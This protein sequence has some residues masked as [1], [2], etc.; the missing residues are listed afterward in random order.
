M[1]VY[2]FRCPTCGVFERWREYQHAGDPMT[3]DACGGPARRVYSVPGVRTAGG[4]FAGATAQQRA[5]Y[6]RS[7]TGEPIVTGPPAG[8]RLGR[9]GG[10]RH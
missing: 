1:P 8:R 4:P 5:R 2:E 10:H 7:R 9:R 6:D 3:C